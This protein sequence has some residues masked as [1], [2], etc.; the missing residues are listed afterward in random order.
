ME[1]G[2][3]EGIRGHCLL[4]KSI[5]TIGKR[6]RH[7]ERN[8]AISRFSCRKERL[9]RLPAGR[10]TRNDIEGCLLVPLSKGIKRMRRILISILLAAGCTFAVSVDDFLDLQYS[11]AGSAEAMRYRLFVPRNYSSAK[12]YPLVL[13]LH[14]CCGCG[15]NRCHV[16]YPALAWAEDSN[17]AKNPC[18]V[19]APQVLTNKI[20]VDWGWGNITDRVALTAGDSGV[21]ISTSMQAVLDIISDL[22]GRY[23]LDTTRFYATGYSMGGW[24]TWDIIVRR[25]NLF[26]AAIPIC[27]GGDTSK[28]NRLTTM[29]IWAF[30]GDQDDAVP[31]QN[32]VLMIAA[33]EKAGGTPKH[34]W[35]INC[36]HNSWDPAYADPQ[37]LPWA[38]S[39]VKNAQTPVRPSGIVRQHAGV[40]D[41]R[42]SLI[43][44]APSGNCG[45]RIM[46]QGRCDTRTADLSGRV[47][48][49]CGLHTMR[50]FPNDNLIPQ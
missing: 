11:S 45:I 40:Q 48:G 50:K 37:L 18:F 33:I 7:C 2:V 19:L 21:K 36:G 5:L 31:F 27:G 34:T 49:R 16:T 17:Q 30:H 10:D 32:S 4:A 28:A 38:F 24:G 14:G 8:E 29:G 9:L 23:S 12:K 39:Q 20:W 35:F 43:I 1:D 25:P 41:R 44:R 26:A 6:V 15:D 46:V 3:E 42:S 13:F 22:K 47:I